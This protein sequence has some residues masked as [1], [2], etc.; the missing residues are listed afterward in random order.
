MSKLNDK[1]NN[2]KD[3]IVDLWNDTELQ[4]HT[5]KDIIDIIEKN[6]KV[7]ADALKGKYLEFT[8]PEHVGSLK[9]S[10]TYKV[11]LPTSH[12]L[13]KKCQ[14]IISGYNEIQKDIQETYL[15]MIDATQ[16]MTQ[17]GQQG[18]K[19]AANIDKHLGQKSVKEEFEE[20]L[21]TTTAQFNSNIVKS[22][23]LREITLRHMG[24]DASSPEVFSNLKE[25]IYT[26]SYFYFYVF[27][28]VRRMI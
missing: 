3:N 7:K 6:V 8:I 5:E 2:D 22:N 23:Q 21:I 19:D 14:P 4:P 11:S 18:L 27:F 24:L 15:K 25:N 13:K 9:E 17:E 28:V 16:L 12:Y 1:D 26:E 10:K 20:W